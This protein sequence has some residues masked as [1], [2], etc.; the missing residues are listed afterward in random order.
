MSS[1]ICYY[2]NFDAQRQQKP[3]VPSLS[4]LLLAHLVLSV[5]L[6]SQS[7]CV[8][9]PLLGFACPESCDGCKKKF[10]ILAPINNM[11][12]YLR[13]VPHW[14]VTRCRSESSL[15]SLQTKWSSI[16]CF[17]LTIRA[18]PLKT[19]VSTT[20]YLALSTCSTILL[21]RSALSLLQRLQII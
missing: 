4:L 16:A 13:N 18:I 1:G 15:L 19:K 5:W 20:M 2:V 14:S 12:M 10:S 8:V 11:K 21:A 17:L 7:F 3:Q 6:L 9:F